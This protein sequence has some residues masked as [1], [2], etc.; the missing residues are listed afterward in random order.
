MAD[1]EGFHERFA[2]LT[3]VLL[4]EPRM[5]GYC[6]T[7]LTD[8]FQEQNGIYRFDRTDKLDVTRVRQAQQRPAAFEHP[9]SPTAG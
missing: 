2:G 7:Q 3:E 9:E 8:T 6:Y 5:F 4:G 1:E